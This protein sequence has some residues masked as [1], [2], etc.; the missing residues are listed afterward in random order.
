MYAHD[1]YWQCMDTPRDLQH[2]TDAWQRPAPP[3][4]V[5]AR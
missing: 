1:G 5:W 2:L 3:W 4:K